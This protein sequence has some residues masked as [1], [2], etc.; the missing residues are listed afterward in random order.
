[1][2][3]SRE[4]RRRRG[5]TVGTK[6]ESEVVDGGTDEN[7]PGVSAKTCMFFVRPGPISDVITFRAFTFAV[8]SVFEIMCGIEFHI[9]RTWLVQSLVQSKFH[10]TTTKVEASEWF[11]FDRWFVWFPRISWGSKHENMFVEF[12]G[13]CNEH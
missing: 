1:M 9:T 8:P 10:T 13:D 12:Q 2:R 3:T 5:K 6:L 4:G 7:F 11:L